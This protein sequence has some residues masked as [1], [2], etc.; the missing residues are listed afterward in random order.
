MALT[1]ST[2]AATGG[3]AGL[4]ADQVAS[5]AGKLSLMTGVQDDV[6]QSGQNML[7]TFKE[8]KARSRSSAPRGPR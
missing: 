6:I 4:T 1:K 7:L 2:I 5:M 3:A 8:I